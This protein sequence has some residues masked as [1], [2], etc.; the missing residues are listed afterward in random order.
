M[1]Y[2][3][4]SRVYSFRGGNGGGIYESSISLNEVCNRIY[5]Y[6]KVGIFVRVDSSGRVPNQP[7]WIYNL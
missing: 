2:S 6:Q 7:V 5:V 3:F 4:R 1:V